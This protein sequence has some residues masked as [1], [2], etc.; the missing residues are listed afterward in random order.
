MLRKSQP[1]RIVVASPVSS[2]QALERLQHEADDCIC[3]MVPPLFTGV[4]SYYD[5]FSEVTDET[6]AGIMKQAASPI[7]E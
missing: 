5:D 4:G 3:L 2:R 7:N 1:A 6:V